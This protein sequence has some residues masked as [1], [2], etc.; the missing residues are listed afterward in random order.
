MTNTVL[1]LVTNRAGDFRHPTF[2]SATTYR[3]KT[4]TADEASLREY[5]GLKDTTT[6]YYVVGALTAVYAFPA[7][8]SEFG[9]DKR[10]F[11]LTRWRP[12]QDAVYPVFL[13]NSRR[14][15]FNIHRVPTEFPVSIQWNLSYVDATTMLVQL[16]TA[17]YMVPVRAAAETLYL[18][19]PEEL[20]I[21]GA[22]DLDGASWT[23]GFTATIL[24]T[25][26]GFPY[27]VLAEKLKNRQDARRILTDRGYM[28]Y[29]FAAQSAMEKC[30]AVYTALAWPTNNE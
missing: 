3:P 7:F 12:D 30:A 10:T 25:P 28:P 5:L 11:D 9:E 6:D 20:G 22:I 8:L 24:H 13:V 23:T 16:G 14:E 29:F 18:D 4:E 17:R 26:I 21:E 15:A 2:D 1:H 19:W 27:D